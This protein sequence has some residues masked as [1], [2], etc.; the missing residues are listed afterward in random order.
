MPQKDEPDPPGRV[1][2]NPGARIQELGGALGVL[3]KA[4]MQ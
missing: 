3:E 2:K 1:I 4:A